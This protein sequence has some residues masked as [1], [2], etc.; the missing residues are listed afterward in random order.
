M[1]FR[2]YQAN[3]TMLDPTS[4]D[5]H[6]ILASLGVADTAGVEAVT[7][8]SDTTVW[9]V[10]W[11]GE[12]YALRLF[13]PEQADTCERE[14]RAMSMAAAGAVTVP[15]V[16]R[17]GVWKDC[18]ALLLSWIAGKPLAHQ[19]REH[20]LLGWR[21]GAA[22]GRMQAAIHQVPIPTDQE[23]TRWIEWAGDEPELKARLYDLPSRRTALIHLDYHPLNV[24]ADGSLVTGVLDWANARTGDS[25]A[26][27]ARTYTILRIEP[28][29]PN[30]DSL[31]LALLR[32]LLER[33]WRTGYV[34]AGGRLDEMALFYAWAGAVM[35]RDLSPR[36][37]KPGHWLYDH[38]LDPVRRWRD[39]WKRRAG[40]Q[41]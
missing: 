40:I 10:R 5:P 34:G 13:R 11:R 29:S 31:Q 23:S 22:F 21:L 35:I 37:G 33:A 17:K 28:Y 20:P 32:R 39:T 24:M 38:H 8:G 16:I 9:R 12:T 1:N 18:P 19:L 27:F 4:L 14:V 30:G 41:M 36:I 3:D 6:P 15:Q 2:I 26:D 7:G 25:R